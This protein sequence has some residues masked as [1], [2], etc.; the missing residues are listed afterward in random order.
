MTT[1]D[2][3]TDKIMEEVN[4]YTDELKKELEQRL[5]RTAD[6]IIE[7]IKENAPRSGRKNALAD[8]FVKEDIGSGYNKTIMIYSKSKGRMIHLIEFGFIHKGGNYVNPRPFLRPA[9]D[10]LTPKM[11]EDVKGIIRGK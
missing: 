5:D 10:Q 2:N 6:E 7:Y 8:S 1:L 3:L 4:N 11:L 9:F